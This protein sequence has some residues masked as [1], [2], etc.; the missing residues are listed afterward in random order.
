MAK[1]GAKRERGPTTGTES[2]RTSLNKSTRNNALSLQKPNINRLFKI[3]QVAHC[4]RNR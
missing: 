1:I 2:A 3:Y 4:I